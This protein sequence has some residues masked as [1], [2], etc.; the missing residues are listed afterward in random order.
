MT[1]TAMVTVE[2]WG[3][4]FDVR[5]GESVFDAAYRHGWQ[6]P[7]NCYGQCR[8]TVCHVR[9]VEGADAMGAPDAGERAVLE[10]LQQTLYRREPDVVLRLASRLVRMATCVSSRDAGQSESTPAARLESG[11]TRTTKT[12]PNRGVGHGECWNRH[13]RWYRRSTGAVAI[14]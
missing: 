13:V 14:R 6:W 4:M 1:S 5:P 8:C 3:I 9:V 2:P 12:T 11:P 7:T 10:T